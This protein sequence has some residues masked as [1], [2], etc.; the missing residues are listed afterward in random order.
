LNKSKT[1]EDLK[2]WQKAHAFTLA[3]YRTSASFPKAEK[4]GLTSQLRRS[5]SS[6]PTNIVEGFNRMGMAEKVRFYNI[7]QASLEEARYHSLLARDLE[8]HSDYEQHAAMAVEVRRMLH[9]L[10]RSVRTNYVKEER[11][12]YGTTPPAAPTTS[13]TDDQLPVGYEFTVDYELVP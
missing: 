3:V 8:Y 2:V 4:F 10:I 9:G 13:L 11:A 1:F 5:A 7:A 12:V 6:I